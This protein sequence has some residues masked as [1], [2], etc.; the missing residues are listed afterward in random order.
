MVTRCPC[1]RSSCAHARLAGPPP[2]QRHALAGVGPRGEEAGVLAQ[3]RVGRVALQ[4][5]DGD[6][7]ATQLVHHALADAQH[8][9]R[10]DARAAHPED[11]GL[12][13]GA[14]RPGD[15]AGGDLADELGD[16][17]V[18]GAGL[19]ARRVAAEEASVGLRHGLRF[20][21]RGL[22]VGEDR[23]GPVGRQVLRHAPLLAT[24]VTP[25]A[26][27][28]RPARRGLYRASIGEGSVFPRES[29]AASRQR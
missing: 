4:L 8:L 3:R 15:V 10:A 24:C 25:G 28:T 23:L 29:D 14:G 1:R 27:S 19:H 26:A 13:D 11:V 22:V 5:A 18:R 17:D 21:Q 6:G 16:V 2:R 9:H 12:E 20:G 7:L